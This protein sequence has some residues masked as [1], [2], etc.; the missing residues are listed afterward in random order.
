MRVYDTSGPYTDP[1]AIIDLT[2]GLPEL[3]RQWVLESRRR[4]RG[5]RSC[6]EAEDDGLNPAR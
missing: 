1:N 3:R 5:G 2:K 4:R 6:P